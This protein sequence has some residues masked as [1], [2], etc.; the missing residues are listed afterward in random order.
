MEVE[1]D[2]FEDVK[3]VQEKNDFDDCMAVVIGLRQRIAELLYCY[4][5]VFFKLLCF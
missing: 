5:V 1:V 4:V 3:I 2:I